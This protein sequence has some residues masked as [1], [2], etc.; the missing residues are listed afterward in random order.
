MLVHKIKKKKNYNIGR[1]FF[2]HHIP[3]K[4]TEYRRYP[5]SHIQAKWQAIYKGSLPLRKGRYTLG[6]Q[7]L[8]YSLQFLNEGGQENII[9]S[10]MSI[11]QIIL[12]HSS[13]STWQIILAH[14]FYLLG[15]GMKVLIFRGSHQKLDTDTP[16]VCSSGK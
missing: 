6:T 11:W 15:Y 10:T 1:H 8:T 13:M 12:A 4:H 9:H 2:L 16:L 14:A 3:D 5:W 7:K